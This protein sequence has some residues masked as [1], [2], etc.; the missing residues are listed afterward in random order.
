VQAIAYAPAMMVRHLE[1]E[2]V[3]DYLEKKSIYGRVNRNPD[4]SP[5]RPLPL[6][7]RLQLA[8]RVIRERR[9]GPG[10]AIGLIGALAAGA[11]Q[12]D[13]QRRRSGGRPHH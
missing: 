7:T 6:R 5:Q 12:F 13:W 2:G 1:I 8:M 3:R 10:T 4:V 11:V 9:L